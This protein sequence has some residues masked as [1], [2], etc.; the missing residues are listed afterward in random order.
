MIADFESNDKSL[1]P[2]KT[3]RK[4]EMEELQMLGEK[5]LKLNHQQL[6]R[7]MLPEELIDAITLAQRITKHEAMRRQT[8]YIGR[9]MRSLDEEIL[10]Q[11]KQFLEGL[12]R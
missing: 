8:Q 3:Q 9:L 2:S 12:K 11:I 5:L 6:S 10:M 1:R 4:R 7:L